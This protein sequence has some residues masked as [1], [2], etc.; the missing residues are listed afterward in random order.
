MY[1]I[2][3]LLHLIKVL[4]SKRVLQKCHYRNICSFLMIM[5]I[6]PFL[7]W[8]YVRVHKEGIWCYLRIRTSYFDFS[9]CTCFSRWRLFCL[10]WNSMLD[11]IFSMS[12]NI[13]D[14][15]E[16]CWHLFHILEH[17]ISHLKCMWAVGLM[18]I[19][20]YNLIL[21]SVGWSAMNIIFR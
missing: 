21:L 13:S 1:P 8:I 2:V 4:K 17:S 19:S 16:R 12:W 7:S 14:A 18:F 11:C 5:Y 6:A 15:C 9:I 3:L 20:S 10:Q